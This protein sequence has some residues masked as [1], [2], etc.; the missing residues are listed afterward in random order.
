MLYYNCRKLMKSHHTTKASLCVLQGL[1]NYAPALQLL[2]K[3]DAGIGRTG[4][5]QDCVVIPIRES[6]MTSEKTMGVI[7]I[8][9]YRMNRFVLPQKRP[10]IVGNLL[11]NI[12]IHAARTPTMLQ[13]IPERQTMGSDQILSALVIGGTIFSKQ[14]K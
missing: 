9:V 1:Y 2:G 7:A 10:K 11:L 3:V 8:K 13:D 6:N 14:R 4:R 5:W 12:G